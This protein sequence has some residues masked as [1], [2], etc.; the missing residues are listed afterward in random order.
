MRDANRVERGQNVLVLCANYH[1]EQE[2]VTAYLD[3]NELHIESDNPQST[4]TKV[5][6][7]NMMGRIVLSR[8]LSINDGTTR[9]PMNTGQSGIYLVRIRAGE[10]TYLRK[11]VDVR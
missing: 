11:V 8:N 5:D 3:G 10:K 2:T 7:F 9:I 4:Q 6:V 1:N